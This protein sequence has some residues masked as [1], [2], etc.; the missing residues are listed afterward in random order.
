[1]PFGRPDGVPSGWPDEA[2][3]EGMDEICIYCRWPWLHAK[4]IARID[5]P[6]SL[7]SSDEL[8]GMLLKFTLIIKLKTFNAF[9]WSNVQVEDLEIDLIY[10]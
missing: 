5:T 1:M 8:N 9:I 6:V 2:P 7:V 4:R 3:Y 10:T